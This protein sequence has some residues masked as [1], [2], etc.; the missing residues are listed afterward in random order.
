MIEKSIGNAD[1]IAAAMQE[2]RDIVH[3][4]INLDN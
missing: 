3:N 2:A 1:V 4:M